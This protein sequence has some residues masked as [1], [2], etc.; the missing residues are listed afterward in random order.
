MLF[1]PC[2]AGYD[3]QEFRETNTMPRL[4]N[5]AKTAVHQPLRLV[6]HRYD[7]LKWRLKRRFG[8]IDPMHIMPYRGFG[9]RISVSISGRVLEAKDVGSPKEDAPWWK[10]VRAMINRFASDE[11]PGAVVRAEFQGQAQETITDDEGYFSFEFP[12]R[13]PLP[14]ERLWHRVALTLV[15]ANKSGPTLPEAEGLVLVPSR[16]SRFGVISDIDDT[17]MYSNATNFWRMAKLTFLNNARTRKP[18]EGVAAFYRALHAGP[19][20][21]HSNPFFYVSSSPWNIYD[22]IHDFLDLNGIPLGPILLRDLGVDKQKFIKEGHEH[23]LE[24]IEQILSVVTDL[25]FLLIGDSGQDDPK[26]YREAIRRFPG[27]IAAI[28]IRDVA[29]SRRTEVAQLIQEAQAD[30]VEM[31]LAADS[32]MAAQHAADRGFIRRDSLDLIRHER[33]DDQHAPESVRPTV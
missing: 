23:K 16:R 9:N 18:F 7:T 2:V 6:E 30:G 20:G 8:W 1:A 24:K 28:Y 31:V 4:L 5:T 21:D 19:E 22:L 25:P 14:E 11:A 26:L 17:V 12:I 27:R 33:H 3:D 15:D 13:R 32:Y 29:E 10:N